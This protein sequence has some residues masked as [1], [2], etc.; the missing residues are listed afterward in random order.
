M[1]TGRLSHW[2][3]V[4]LGLV[5]CGCVAVPSLELNEPS[6]LQI[7]ESRQVTLEALR[8]DVSGYEQ[9]LTRAD[10]LTLPAE[11]RQGIWLYDLDLRG[12]AGQQRLMD[13]ALTSIQGS[14]L[15]D[16][17]LG[18]AER[19]MIRLL[20]MTPANADLRGTP[21]NELLSLAPQIGF[22]AA[23]VLA[24]SLDI[25][26]DEPFLASNALSDALVEGI[27]SSHPN[28]QTRPI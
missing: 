20:N 11:T 28:T 1:S 3:W 21:M 10:L 18:A 4:W 17:T 7:G 13:H 26:V 6:P 23:E 12:V 2:I 22:A 9:V 19:N 27:I 8:M 24:A 16:P 15:T 5:L 14:V 25:E